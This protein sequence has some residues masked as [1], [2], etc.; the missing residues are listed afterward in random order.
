MSGFGRFFIAFDTSDSLMT[1]PNLPKW[2]LIALPAVAII[3][4]IFYFNKYFVIDELIHANYRAQTLQQEL[5][6]TFEELEK[7]K[8]RAT[9]AEREADVVRQAN[10][11]L[12]ASERD[13]QDETPGYRLIWHFTAVSVAP[14]V[15]RLR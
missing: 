13:H 15:H 2:Q 12:R 10:A 7:E 8:A 1:F 9:V 3:L 6:A 5:Q 11:L 14:M 4:S